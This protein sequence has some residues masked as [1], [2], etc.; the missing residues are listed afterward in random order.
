MEY[1]CRKDKN[2]ILLADGDIVAQCT[3][4]DVIWDGKAIIRR[5]PLGIVKT[6][7]NSE[8]LPIMEPE[9]TDCY[10]VYEI[11]KGVVE[12]TDK[13]DEWMKTKLANED[14]YVDLCISRYDGRFHGWDDIEKIGSIYDLTD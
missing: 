8:Q 13:A 6:Y 10:N 1:T 3:L 14:G 4:G 5:R 7:K 9:E 12:L 11:R 2:N